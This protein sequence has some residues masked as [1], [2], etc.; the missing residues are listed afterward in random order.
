LVLASATRTPHKLQVTTIYLHIYIVHVH[1]WDPRP[2][3]NVYMYEKRLRMI[4]NPCEC[5]INCKCTK[6]T[7]KIHPLELLTAFASL[8]KNSIPQPN[9]RCELQLLTAKCGIIDTNLRIKYSIF[10]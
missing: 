4:A 3:H 5:C 10:I 7:E 2:V 1:L 9:T 6:V 8:N